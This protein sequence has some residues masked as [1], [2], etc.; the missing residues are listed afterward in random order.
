M[1]QVIERI[2]YIYI[3]IYIYITSY[4]FNIQENVTD[5]CV[6]CNWQLSQLLHVTLKMVTFTAINIRTKVQENQS[7]GSSV[8]R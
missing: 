4:W 6:Y 2:I 3:Y 5:T 1:F 8:E 7:N